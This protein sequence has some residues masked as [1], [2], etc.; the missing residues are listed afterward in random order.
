MKSTVSQQR[1]FLVI[2]MAVTLLH[3]LLLLVPG[4]R[5]AVLESRLVRNLELRLVRPAPEPPL[6]EPVL[7][8]PEAA[9]VE[10][11]GPH[12]APP[13]RT[14]MGQEARQTVRPEPETEPPQTPP[15]ASRLLSRQFDLQKPEPLF[16]PA[17]P[18][19]VAQADAVARF[20]P[21]LDEVLNVPSLQLPF[22]DTRIY[23]VETYSPGFAGS[24]E[25]FFDEVTVPFGWTT[26][27][28][29]RFQCAWVLILAGCSWGHVSLFEREARKRVPD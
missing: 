10:K 8:E 7:R 27:S 22:E 11:L 25:R 5:H 19:T 12:P 28:N 4:V 23:L 6:T 20:R 9:V 16:A 1:R 13:E 2:L 26:K 3:L 17:N 24:V 15:V 18:G 14:G 29:T 21:V